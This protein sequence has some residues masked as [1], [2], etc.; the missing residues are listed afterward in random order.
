ML[1]DFIS[2]HDIYVR[3]QVHAHLNGTETEHTLFLL[4]M[5]FL[6]YCP[7]LQNTLNKAFLSRV[8]LNK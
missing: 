8:I 6:Q 1:P 2:L 4:V 5:A 3:Y 7:L